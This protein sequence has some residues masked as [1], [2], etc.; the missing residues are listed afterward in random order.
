MKVILNSYLRLAVSFAKK[1]KSYGLPIDDLIHE[2]VL[3]IMHALEKFDISKGFRLSTYAS[4][5]IRSSI[6]NFI[7]RNW[8][9]V[10]TGTTAAQ[11]SLSVNVST[12]EAGAALSHAP[13]PRPEAPHRNGADG[14]GSRAS[15]VGSGG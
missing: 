11:K 4:W 15:G 8:S 13:A 12:S 5:W 3:G 6:Q 2:G 10:R 14:A 7:L 1:Y 9:I